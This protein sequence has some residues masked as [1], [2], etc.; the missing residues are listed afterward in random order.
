MKLQT[1]YFGEVDYESA[2]LICFSEGL[3]G[4]QEER[5]FLL[6]P[7]ADS[8]SQM[9]CL[10]SVNTPALAFILLDPFSLC[11]DYAPELQPEELKALGAEKV[12][13]LA[14]YV[15]CAVHS[16]ASESTVNLRC[17]LAIHPHT[18]QARQIIM[19]SERY[20]MRSLLSSFGGGG[21]QC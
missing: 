17:P 19:G 9:L 12:E 5:E 7:F 10:Q 16:P 13:D 20:A 2:E 15:L 6:L 4:F 21:E 14:F 3:P 1:K 18:L 11:P 8:N